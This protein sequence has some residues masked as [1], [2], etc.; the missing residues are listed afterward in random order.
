MKKVERVFL[1]NLEQGGGQDKA[2]EKSKGVARV[3]M[4]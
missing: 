2:V 4:C 1:M 3:K